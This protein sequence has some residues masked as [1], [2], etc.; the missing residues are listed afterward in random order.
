MPNFFL[1]FVLSRKWYFTT[2]MTNP[3]IKEK[4]KKYSAREKKK[5]AMC[6]GLLYPKVLKKRLFCDFRAEE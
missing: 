4:K 6:P 2:K 5:R 3:V 1:H